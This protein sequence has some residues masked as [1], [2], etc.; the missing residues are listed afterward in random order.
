M[1]NFIAEFEN[2]VFVFCETM[3]DA[4]KDQKRLIKG[5]I[6]SN[7]STEYTEL[8]TLEIPYNN[9]EKVLEVLK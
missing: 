8:W 7:M 4:I 3:E 6:F 9:K 2:K 5:G 1:W